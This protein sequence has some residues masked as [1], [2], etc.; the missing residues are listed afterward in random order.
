MSLEATLEPI[1]AKLQTAVELELT[2]IPP[3]L[4]ALYSI[5][6]GKNVVASNLIRSVFMEE[7]LHM[8]LASNVLVSIGGRL[9]LSEANVPTYPCRLKFEGKTFLDR[10]FDVHLAA[11]SKQ[12]LHDFMQIELPQFMTP[13][14]ASGAELVVPGYTVGEFY[15]SI[16]DELTKACEAF[17][18]PQV[19]HGGTAHQ[20]S[21][22]YFWGGDGKPIVVTSLET[23]KEAIDL[24][25]E[26]GEGA[27][28]D[29][30]QVNGDFFT[31]AKPHYFRF[32]EIHEGRLYREIDPPD[33]P[34]TGD[35]LPVNFEDVFPIKSDCKDAD[36]GGHS[37]LQHLN[38]L[39]NSNYTMMLS[40]IAEGFNGNPA[41]FYTAIMN[42]M[43]NLTP[44]ARQMVAIPIRG[45]TQQRHGAPSFEWLVD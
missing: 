35:P 45:D 38:R 22:Q 44:L 40:Q 26:Q 6:P 11:L 29:A 20:V 19:F 28:I 24:I 5:K 15:K 41:A 17:G 18:E 32:K 8:I 14:K 37:E 34:P 21:E 23:A 16:A 33:G 31:G 42:G 43:H 1:R 12:S 7:M 4:M 39:F 30:N 9:S 25:V 10:E 27:S 3:Y 36:F 13:F 2:T